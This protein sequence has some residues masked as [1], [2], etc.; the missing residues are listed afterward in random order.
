M[1]GVTSRKKEGE[2]CSI[3]RARYVMPITAPMVEDG[4]VVVRLG[5]ILAIG[6]YHDLRVKYWGSIVHD[7][8]EVILMPG[9]I[10]AHA[11]LDY[12]MMRGQLTSGSSFTDWIKQLNKIK[13]SL[14]PEDFLTAIVEGAQELRSWGCT[15]L[16]NIESFPDLHAKLPLLPIR[17]WQFIEVMDIRGRTQGEVGLAAAEQ[18]LQKN[19][20]TQDHFGIS[21]HA[22]YTSSLSLYQ[23]AARL[24]LKYK[25][26]FCTHL[27]ESE[28]EIEM[29]TKRE[30]CLFEF[31]KNLKRDMSDC[32]SSTAVQALLKNDLLPRGA[33]LVHMNF[34][35]SQDRLLL[36]PRGN[37]F[38]IIHCPK[39]HR[40]L[41]RPPFEWKFFYQNRYPI[42]LGTDSLASNNSLNLFEE[43]QL[44]ISTAP[45]LEPEEV[46]KMVT[47]YPAAAIKMQRHLGELAQGAYADMIAIPF[48]GKIEK[49]SE[50]VVH[51]T[52]F[53]TFTQISY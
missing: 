46:L 11:H 35:S 2:G 40:F 9:L 29:F 4:A 42:L 15:T 25:A 30:G 23:D 28:E 37:D 47:L 31:V 45:H 17:L 6:K 41:R 3:Y 38:F 10:N 8:G 16:C 22:P 24:S 27:A 36:A 13:S 14:S 48:V 43:M 12:T 7:L 44:M 18:L 26:P 51:N 5:I 34:L 19:G 53:P 39:T 20:W 32:G 49:A 50:A 21:P 52:L 33:M 1:M